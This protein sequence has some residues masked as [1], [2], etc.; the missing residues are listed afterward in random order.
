M[1]PFGIPKLISDSWGDLRYKEHSEK[2]RTENEQ[3]NKRRQ[4]QKEI[5]LRSDD[6]GTL[7]SHKTEFSKVLESQKNK[8]NGLWVQ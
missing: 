3:N 2:T 7:L 4:R 5:I 6:S 8:N 1:Y